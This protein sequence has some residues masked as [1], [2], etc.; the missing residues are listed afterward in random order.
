MSKQS[1]IQSPYVST[2]Q[3]SLRTL[4]ILEHCSTLEMKQ[5]NLKKKKN[6]KSQ[7]GNFRLELRNNN[8]YLSNITK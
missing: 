8:E 6:Q 4:G 1:K 2:T 7:K 3:T 5:G